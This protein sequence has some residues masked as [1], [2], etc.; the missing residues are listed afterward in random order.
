VSNNH[1]TLHHGGGTIGVC[2]ETKE[3]FTSRRSDGSHHVTA[4]LTP[5]QALFL[6]E[7]LIRRVREIQKSSL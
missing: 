3:A 2:L 5:A 4:E 7:D 1:V 6:A